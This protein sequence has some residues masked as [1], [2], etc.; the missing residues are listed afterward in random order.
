MNHS[1]QPH[2][3]AHQHAGATPPIAVYELSGIARAAVLLR[4]MMRNIRQN[5]VFA[6]GYNALRLNRVRL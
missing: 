5:L 3:H 1:H 6:F 2:A 4:A